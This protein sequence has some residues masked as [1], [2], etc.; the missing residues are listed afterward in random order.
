[1]MLPDKC[2]NCIY[3]GNPEILIKPHYLKEK[4]YTETRII[5]RCSASNY[6]IGCVC[7]EMYCKRKEQTT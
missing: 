6:I 4:S 7:A 5:Q 2:N 1:M 3:C